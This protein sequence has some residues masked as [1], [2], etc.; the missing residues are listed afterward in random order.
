MIKQLVRHYYEQ[1]VNKGLS[2]ILYDGLGEWEEEEEDE[3]IQAIYERLEENEDFPLPPGYVHVTEK[4]ETKQFYL[5][6]QILPFVK[7]SKTVVVYIIDELL[8]KLFGI[9]FLEPYVIYEEETKVKAVLN[10]PKVEIRSVDANHIV[11]PARPFGTDGKLRSAKL[12]PL[13]K[14]VLPL[15]LKMLVYDQ[16]PEEQKFYGEVA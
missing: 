10:K 9:H 5:P 12:S 14:V 16:E 3:V 4:I 11:N 6:T 8:E 7:K 15:N 13:S 2:T 1:T